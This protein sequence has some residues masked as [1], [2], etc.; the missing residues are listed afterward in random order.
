MTNSRP[1]GPDCLIFVI[2][3]VSF[4]IALL[5]DPLDSTIAELDWVPSP[6]VRPLNRLGITTGRALLDH[7]PSLPEHRAQ[8]TRFPTP[9]SEKPISPLPSHNTLSP[10]H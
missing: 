10:P 5:M 7:Y 1:Q 9:N 2:G 3:H 8:F 6:I 4:V